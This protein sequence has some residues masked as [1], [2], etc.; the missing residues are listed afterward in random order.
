MFYAYAEE[1]KHN[2]CFLRQNKL[3]QYVQNKTSKCLW[4]VYID[5]FVVKWMYF[6]YVFINHFPKIHRSVLSKITIDLLY[7][8]GIYDVNLWEKN[9]AGLWL[10]YAEQMSLYNLIILWKKQWP[11]AFLKRDSNTG[12]RGWLRPKLTMVYHVWCPN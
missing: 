4:S 2:D 7:F 11:A 9:L 5:M 12:V 6:L 1:Y 3:L 10:I 8:W